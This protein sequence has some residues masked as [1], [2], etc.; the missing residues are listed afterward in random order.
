MVAISGG[1]HFRPYAPTAALDAQ[2]EPYDK[3]DVSLT[4]ISFDSRRT[5]IDW[6]NGQLPLAVCF[7]GYI[8]T[9]IHAGFQQLHEF[10]SK[11]LDV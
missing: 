8:V 6:M 11:K 5:G 3:T 1:L 4:S 2:N 10:D 7:I 9:T